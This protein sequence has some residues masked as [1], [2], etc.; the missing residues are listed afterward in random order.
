M[1]IRT[2]MSTSFL[3][4]LLSACCHG[5]SQTLTVA[6][7]GSGQFVTVQA[8]VDAVPANN[9]QRVVI[10]IKPGTYKEHIVVPKDKPFITFRGEDAATTILTD[11]KNVNATD[12]AGVKLKT[13]DS[14]STLILG[15]DFSAENITFENTAGNHGQAMALYFDSDR[16]V[17]KNCRFLGWQDT[18]R[19][20]YGRSY[21]AD[22][23]IAGHVDFIYGKG[24]VVFERCEIRSVA[25]GYIT[26]ASTPQGAPF[27]YAFFDCRLT[28]E[29]AAKRVYLGRPCAISPPWLLSA[30]K[31]AS[32]SA[33]KAGTTGT[34]RTR[35]RPRDMP[36]TSAPGR[37]R[38]AR[39]V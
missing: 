14:S 25:D 2:L 6:A 20:N 34:S 9:A 27:G 30:A 23:Y 3:A 32:T 33:P 11:D 12:S 38:I 10:E 29:P 22:C 26:A 21:F 15:K 4:L 37:V 24:V 17:F 28:A 35:K 1:K 31:W 39:N 16:G 18:L 7:D 19:V 13:P 36:N 8:A 5:Q